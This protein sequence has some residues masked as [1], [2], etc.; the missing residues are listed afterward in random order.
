MSTSLDLT[1]AFQGVALKKTP[2]AWRIMVTSIYKPC[3]AFGKGT[4]LLRRLIN[5]TNHLLTQMILQLRRFLVHFGRPGHVI[6]PVDVS[7]LVRNLTLLLPLDIIIIR[8]V[9]N[10][11]R[12]SFFKKNIQLASK[13][14]SDRWLCRFIFRIVQVGPCFLSDWKNNWHVSPDFEVFFT[15]KLVRAFAVPHVH[16]ACAR[17]CPSSPVNADQAVRD[18]PRIEGLHVD[19]L[20]PILLGSD[21]FSLQATRTTTTTTTTNNDTILE[22][23]SEM[24]LISF[25][26]YS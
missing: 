5:H 2:P 10:I 18:P 20:S 14:M 24:K 16:K 26:I 15:R 6:A 7:C 4:T 23:C 12:M 11:S 13:I 19:L 22:S 9:R 17:C 3:R 21:P 1:E 25:E 8:P